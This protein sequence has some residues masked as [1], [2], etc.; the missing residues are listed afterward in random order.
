MDFRKDKEVWA[1]SRIDEGGQAQSKGARK[2][3]GKSKGA[4]KST[5]ADDGHHGHDTAMFMDAGLVSGSPSA[6]DLDLSGLTAATDAESY[7]DQLS[8]YHDLLSLQYF[9]TLQQ[10]Q[11]LADPN[12]VSDELEQKVM[13][14]Y[15][16]LVEVRG[17]LQSMQ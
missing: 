13:L 3:G 7:A 15:Q 6:P 8:T 2:S 12:D 1:E 11:A 9:Q 14:E 16:Q 5:S 4:R 17:L 10:I